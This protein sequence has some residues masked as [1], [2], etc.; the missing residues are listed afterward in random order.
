MPTLSC[1]HPLLRRLRRA[2]A[3]DDR[4]SV[5]RAAPSLSSDH[6]LDRAIRRGFD[7]T[8]QEHGVGHGVERALALRTLRCWSVYERLLDL[9]AR[10][11]CSIT[12]CCCYE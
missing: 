8:A 2:G 9:I 3:R 4:R 11:N 10:L 12:L 1:L 7:P 5:V 6:T